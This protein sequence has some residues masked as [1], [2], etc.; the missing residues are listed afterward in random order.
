MSWSVAKRTRQDAKRGMLT[1]VVSLRRMPR[2]LAALLL[3]SVV[4]LGLG[5]T[6]VLA[7]SNGPQLSNGQQLVVYVGTSIYSVRIT[8]TNQNGTPV[9][10]DY[11]TPNQANY[12]S[13]YYWKG[14][15]YIASYTGSNEG[16]TY[17]GTK[18]CTVPTSYAGSYYPCYGYGG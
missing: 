16:G 9:T 17:K 2:L 7:V 12:D 3:A 14:I 11:N 13:G 8:G 4:S 10:Q 6:D 1:G 15:T 18:E 5:A